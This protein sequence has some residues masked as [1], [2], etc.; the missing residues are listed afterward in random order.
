[1]QSEGE[2]GCQIEIRK[3]KQ[4]TSIQLDW[5]N[6]ENQIVIMHLVHYSSPLQST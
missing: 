4:V 3:Q 6:G 5:L 2:N 1:M